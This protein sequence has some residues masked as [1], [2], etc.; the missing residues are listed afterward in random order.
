[1][2]T[3][4]PHACDGTR[5]VAPH[6]RAEGRRA[7]RARLSP[8]ALADLTCNAATTL[9]TRRHMDLVDDAALCAIR[10]ER[11]RFTRDA[12]PP[13][14]QRTLAPPSARE[15]SLR[16]VRHASPRAIA[17]PP[18]LRRAAIR[19]DYSAM[20]A[21]RIACNDMRLRRVHAPQTHKKSPASLRG[22]FSLRTAGRLAPARIRNPCRPCRPCRRPCRQRRRP[23]R[24]FS[25]LRPPSLRW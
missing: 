10:C 2:P 8:D 15:A 5:C 21:R 6:R 24:P 12:P 7:V 25:A 19:H 4:Q 20:R 3:A 23:A 14:A 18:T 11:R 22:S 9:S 17:L 13:A 1:M 16:A